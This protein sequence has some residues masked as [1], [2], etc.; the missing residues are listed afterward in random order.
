M[1]QMMALGLEPASQPMTKN[2]K[3]GNMVRRDQSS[4]FSGAQ[5]ISLPEIVKGPGE[6]LSQFQ[7][8]GKRYSRLTKAFCSGD[9]CNRHGKGPY[10]IQNKR[11]EA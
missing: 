4:V 10:K 7:K 9:S 1:K 8:T 11:T 5:I 3:D 6:C 2:D